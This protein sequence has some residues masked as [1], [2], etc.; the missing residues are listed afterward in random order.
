M[1][2]QAQCWLL[3]DVALQKILLASRGLLLQLQHLHTLSPRPCM[4]LCMHHPPQPQPKAWLLLPPSSHHHH[5]QPTRT[6]RICL[7]HVPVGG[8]QGQH[9]QP[10]QSMD[11]CQAP[12]CLLTELLRNR[13]RDGRQAGGHS[14]DGFGY[15][16]IVVGLGMHCMSLFTR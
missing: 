7:V 1:L 15:G 3:P 13:R 2:W 4:Y 11:T 6:Q 10:R 8:R 9:L 5:H 16:R 14:S 12:A